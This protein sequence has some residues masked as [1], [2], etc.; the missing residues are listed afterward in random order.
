MKV[1]LMLLYAK[2]MVSK[3]EG[4]FRESLPSVPIDINR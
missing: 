3:A 4:M 1:L 2:A